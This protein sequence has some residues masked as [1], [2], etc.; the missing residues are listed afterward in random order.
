M[1]RL[2][3][4][5]AV[6]AML[7][8]TSPTIAIAQGMTQTVSAVDTKAIA[9]G[10]R[11]SKI[12]KN[13]PPDPMANLP[14]D[15]KANVERIAVEPG[16]FGEVLGQVAPAFS[17]AASDQG[18][19]LLKTFQGKPRVVRTHPPAQGQPCIL[20]SPVTVVA[21]K[22]TELRMTVAHHP[23]ADWQLLVF[24]NGE[25]LH[26]ALIAANTTQEGWADVV[27]DLSR[28]AGRNIVLEVHNHPNNW[29]SEYAYWQRLEV[30]VH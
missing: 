2:A 1:K 13:P 3:T 11:S 21:G 15:V 8:A 25:K 14:P 18:V 10:Y 12:V 9:T 17:T 16:R 27:I 28:F 19:W 4:L 24:A 30:I 23:Q 22:K 26:D 29:A 7:A 6:G 20:R 5:A